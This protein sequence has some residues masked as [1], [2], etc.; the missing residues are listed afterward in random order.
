MFLISTLTHTLWITSHLRIYLLKSIMNEQQLWCSCLLTVCFMWNTQCWI[1]H[2]GATASRDESMAALRALSSSSSST[3]AGG[4]MVVTSARCGAQSVVTS[5]WVG[6]RL[7]HALWYADNKWSSV[8]P[9]HNN[10][11]E[12]WAPWWLH[13]VLL[14]WS[15]LFAQ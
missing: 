10:C 8:P 9:V 11:Q 6:S 2:C 12:E 1:G 15:R 5:V 4:T 14:E 3:A 7:Q 13:E